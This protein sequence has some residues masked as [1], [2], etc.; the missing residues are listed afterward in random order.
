M[1]K[2]IVQIMPRAEAYREG[3]CSSQFMTRVQRQAADFTIWLGWL[4][5]VRDQVFA[6]TSAQKAYFDR[7]DALYRASKLEGF[8]D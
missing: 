4:P 2:F 6:W 8:H 7:M 1:L 3:E 5:G